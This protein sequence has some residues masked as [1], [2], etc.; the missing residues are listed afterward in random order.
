MDTIPKEIWESYRPQNWS[1]I[2]K[3]LGYKHPKAMS[4]FAR[5][6]KSAECSIKPDRKVLP[7]HKSRVYVFTGIKL[8][9]QEEFAESELGI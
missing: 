4:V 2:G 1:A 3:A 6:L 9:P 8:L 5:D 7:E